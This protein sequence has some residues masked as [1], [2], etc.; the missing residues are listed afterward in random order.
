MK[1]FDPYHKWLGIPPEEQPPHHYRLLGLKTFESDSE[2]VDAAADRQM[3]FL[4]TCATGEH[5]EASQNLLNRVSAARVCLLNSNKK[6][7]YDTKLKA[8][9]A[10]RTAT[11][12]RTNAGAQFPV[13]EVGKSQS[14]AR[15]TGQSLSKRQVKT[16]VIV[17]ALAVVTVLTVFVLTRGSS[18]DAEQVPS[19]PIAEMQ[20]QSPEKEVSKPPEKDIEAKDKLNPPAEPAKKKEPAAEPVAKIDSKPTASPTGRDVTPLKSSAKPVVAPVSTDVPNIDKSNTAP[21]P[22]EVA[23]VRLPIPDADTV[24]QARKQIKTFYKDD[25]KKK[26]PVDKLALAKK[27]LQAGIEAKKKPVEQY[28]FLQESHELAAEAGDV[29][30]AFSAIDELQKSFEFDDVLELKSAVLSKARRV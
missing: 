19:N 4:Q 8:K 18:D 14:T 11:Y 23:A 5:V 28:V 13:I 16:F 7:A 24:E 25:Y 20:P 27:L 26:N 15:P 17:G 6:A 29:S 9:L 10:Q 22:I 21:P 1:D 30:T 2:V 3:A 12:D